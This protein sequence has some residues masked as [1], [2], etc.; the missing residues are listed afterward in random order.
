MV[1]RIQLPLLTLGLSW[2]IRIDRFATPLASH[3]SPSQLIPGK[4]EPSLSA[5]HAPP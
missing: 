4:I 5:S 3:L 1:K 2:A